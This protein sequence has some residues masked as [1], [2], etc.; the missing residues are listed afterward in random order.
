MFLNFSTINPYFHW[1]K[2]SQLPNLM[3][4]IILIPI[5]AIST[6]FGAI[7]VKRLMDSTYQIFF[8]NKLGGLL[9]GIGAYFLIVIPVIGG[10]SIGIIIIHFAPETKGRNILEMLKTMAKRDHALPPRA[11]AIHALSST[12]YVGAGGSLGLGSPTGQLGGA[13]GSAI[14]HFVAISKEQIRLLFA[15]GVGAGIAA[16]FHA[17]IMGTVFT[18]EVVL[19]K[20]FKTIDLSAI[21]ISALIADTIV[22]LYTEPFI[23][24]ILPQYTYNN[25]LEFFLFALLGVVIA[26][27]TIAFNQSL[28]NMQKFWRVLPISDYLKPMLGGLLLGIVGLVSFKVGGF[29]RLFGL[30]T[31]SISDVF[32][33]SLALNVVFMLFLLKIFTTTLGLSSGGTGGLFTPSFFIG[34]MLGGTFGY[35]MSLLFPTL[36]SSIGIYAMA[37]MAAFVSG[38][39]YAPLTALVVGFELIGHY[40]ILWP[41]MLTVGISSFITHTKLLRR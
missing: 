14:G 12:I 17:P 6:G 40:Q 21:L 30:G 4:M 34:A 39:L 31:S 9:E 29:P 20:Q 26:I 24:I 32:N 35:L 23:F 28:S 19:G 41:I 5:V 25:I 10:L 1:L 8:E 36:S 37:G 7:G 16:A 2:F 11:L 3:V 33:G 18:L 22:Q 38:T 13:L 15:C 27:G